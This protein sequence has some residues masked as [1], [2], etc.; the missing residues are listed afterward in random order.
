M[1]AT[2]ETPAKP[3]AAA[4]LRL[5]GVHHLALN[6]DDM[7]KTTDFYVR[8]L[9]MRLVHGLVTAKG[10][11]ARAARRGNPPVDC[12][13]HY[14]FD[15]GGDSLLAFFEF[16]KGTAVAD[17]NTLATMQH[18]AFATAPEHFDA[19]LERVRSH[20]VP[21]VSGPLLSVP[22]TTWSFYFFDPNGIRLEICTN[23]AAAP[24]APLD[25]I[26]SCALSREEMRRELET[27][28]RDRDW[29]E[30]ILDSMPG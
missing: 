16:P 17:R 27:L 30:R 15:M 12:I 24:D 6:T 5:R 19:L 18:V 8:V 25:V 1:A 14:F 28:S 2:F 10:A 4:A 20:G 7:A 13:R 22:P 23:K 9:G 29:I 21:I 11:A 26:G 3:A